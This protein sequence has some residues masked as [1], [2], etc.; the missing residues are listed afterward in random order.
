MT[1]LQLV[2]LVPPMCRM[3][4]DPDLRQALAAH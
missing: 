3:A 4:A 2:A 1:L